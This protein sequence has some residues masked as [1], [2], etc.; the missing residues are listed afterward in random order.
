MIKVERT[1][2][3]E[4]LLKQG[5]KWLKTIQEA[6]DLAAKAITKIEKENAKSKLELALDKYKHDDIKEALATKMFH[7]K[8]AYCEAKITHIDYGDI[9]HFRPKDTFPLLA[10][11][12]ENLLL[13]CRVC[14]G[15]A[16][17]GTKFP[18]DASANPL[19]INPCKDEPNN[20]L[21][22]EFDDIT[23]FAIVVSKDKKGAE[24]E[25]NYGLNRNRSK[26]D[27]LQHRSL[28]VQKLIFIATFYHQEQRAKEL[29][30]S[31]CENTEEYSAFAKMVREKYVEKI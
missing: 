8:C 15:A 1:E 19:L 7:G 25:K 16:F 12:W 17:K 18:L 2:K 30:D 13:A 29:L 21:E 6:L 10:V 24:S 20:H 14:N 23:K 9:E 28:A 5:V 26:D 3:P 27:L 22:F 11:E 31:A 4:A